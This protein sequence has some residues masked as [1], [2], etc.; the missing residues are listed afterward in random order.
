MK[1][2]NCYTQII[3]L[4]GDKLMSK[5]VM[6]TGLGLVTPIGNQVD[7][8]W[9]NLINGKSGIDYIKSFDQKS[10]KLKLLQKLRNL[11]LVKF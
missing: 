3:N 8:A 9:N 2:N 7:I 10:M 6:V 5:K 11:I 1:I 4:Y